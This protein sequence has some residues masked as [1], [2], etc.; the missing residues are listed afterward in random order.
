MG[1]IASNPTQDA[2][3]HGIDSHLLTNSGKLSWDSQ[4]MI[5]DKEG[6]L[7]YGLFSDISLTPKLGTMHNISIDILDNQLDISDLGFL[8]R[9]DVIGASYRFMKFTSRGLPKWMRTKR[10]GT[11][12]QLHS[13]ADGYLTEAWLGVMGT[14]LTQKN[15][16]ISA[17]AG[18]KPPQ[19]DDRNSRGNGSY[20]LDNT[21]WSRATIGTNSAKKFSFSANVEARSE[22]LGH[23]TYSSTLGFTYAPVDRFSVDLD[24]GWKKRN[25]WLIYIGD[26]KFTS[27]DAIEIQPNLSMN[28]FISSKQQLRLRLQWAGIDADQS[29]FWTIEKELR[30]V[31]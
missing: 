4:L 19:Y 26:R 21:F 14:W 16:E 28:F 1:T 22:D 18:F 29:Q 25:E 5:S 11:F 3:V 24:I 23:I 9:N 30:R 10:I 6:E 8:R 31:M 13:N 2:V 20:R 7:G 15:L 17:N 27:F 12:T